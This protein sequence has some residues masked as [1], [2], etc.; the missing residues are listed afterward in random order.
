MILYMDGGSLEIFC[1]SSMAR[2]QRPIRFVRSSLRG[3]RWRFRGRVRR[4]W[5]RG[6]CSNVGR[7]RRRWSRRRRWHGRKI[8]WCGGRW[9]QR[10]C[11]RG[12]T[13][14]VFVST[15][16]GTDRHGNSE[17]DANA[18]RRQAE[19]PDQRRE[20]KQSE[21]LPPVMSHD[22]AAALEG[23]PEVEALV[24]DQQRREQPPRHD[25]IDRRNHTQEKPDERQRMR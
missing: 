8:G 18:A 5:R 23:R 16:H 2:F 10:V 17:E 24:K 21:A 14:N 4:N 13:E 7:R 22:P 3:W 25:Q 6:H 15:D 11:R 12:R 19:E 20:E 9:R 1:P